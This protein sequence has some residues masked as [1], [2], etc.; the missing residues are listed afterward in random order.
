MSCTLR[1]HA[2]HP[3]YNNRN[4]QSMSG[5]WGQKR[6]LSHSNINSLTGLGGSFLVDFFPIQ[7]TT[8]HSYGHQWADWSF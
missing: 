4:Q 7:L 8:I 5:L 1:F 2:Q 3:S 6:L